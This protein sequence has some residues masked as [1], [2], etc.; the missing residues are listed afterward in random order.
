MTSVLRLLLLLIRT[1]SGR[2]LGFRG[3]GSACEVKG[4]GSRR[5]GRACE[6]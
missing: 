5:L 3:L 2:G 1:L 4:L 6:V